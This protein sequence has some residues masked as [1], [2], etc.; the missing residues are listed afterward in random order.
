[1]PGEPVEVERPMRTDFGAPPW[2][3]PLPLP[4]CELPAISEVVVVGAG[5]TGLAAALTMAEAG[6]D[7]TVV[8]RRFGSGATSRSGGIVLGD[9]LVG[10]RAGFEECD[11]ALRNWIAQ[12]GA[13]CNLFW[14]G[15]VELARDES[16]SSDPIDWNEH[17]PVRLAGR[18]SG[19]V[20]DPAKLQTELAR[21]AR[22]AGTTIVDGVVVLRL[23]PS[24]PSSQGVVVVTERG[25]IRAEH[26]IMAVDVMGWRP[27]FDPWTERVITVALTTGP[28][29]DDVLAAIGLSPHQAFYTRD[30]PLL[31]GRVM[32]NR[33]L[34]VG[35]ETLP[36]PRA[37]SE[38]RD[39]R[40]EE[41]GRN[42]VSR[43]RGL[44]PALRDVAVDHVWGG[45]IARTA[46][47]VPAAIQ[48]P[49][50]PHVHWVGGYGGHGL[51]QAFRMGRLVSTS[52]EAARPD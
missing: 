3:P 14:K 1:M 25:S 43:V 47:G 48:D 20:L 35:R 22:R 27:P 45:P 24:F 12:S 46:A 33:S 40:L 11:L 39:D 37:D 41:A 5:I 18:I 13:E 10:P 9:T 31:W 42:L 16:L 19:G 51:A 44:H 28:L 6:Q 4:P 34:L 15:C 7:V 38:T 23:E 2:I 49:R 21:I 26:V 32:P 36:W 8:E 29:T 17:G 52:S 50:I 30:R